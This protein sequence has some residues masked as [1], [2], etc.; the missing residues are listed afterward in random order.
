MGREEGGE[1][2]ISELK[3]ETRLMKE[4]NTL[5]KML[6]PMMMLT[7]MMNDSELNGRQRRTANIVK[8]FE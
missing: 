2:W 1:G 3:I 5:A 6:M 8:F 7:S 4:P